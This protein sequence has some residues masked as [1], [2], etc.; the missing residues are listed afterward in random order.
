[1]GDAFLLKARLSHSGQQCVFMRIMKGKGIYTIEHDST[2]EKEAIVVTETEPSNFS[3][4]S[5][6]CMCLKA[7]N[8]MLLIDGQRESQNWFS[9]ILTVFSPAG[10]QLGNVRRRGF[11]LYSQ[12]DIFDGNM[13]ELFHLKSDPS[14]IVILNHSNTIVATVNHNT[15]N[16]TFDIG[17]QLE[18]SAIEKFLILICI[19]MWTK[20][21]QLYN[22]S[23]D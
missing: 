7:G 22:E 6:K 18:T 1:M 4:T 16:A 21:E 9:D 23:Q 19:L 2:D 5:D 14:A 20:H 3:L 13:K 12:Y 17:Y 10:F 8:G 15:E 11:D